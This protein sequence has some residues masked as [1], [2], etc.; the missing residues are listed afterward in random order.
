MTSLIESTPK[1]LFGQVATLF[2]WYHV[3]GK[4]TTVLS[5]LH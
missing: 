2:E 5:V 3:Y 1:F 4:Q